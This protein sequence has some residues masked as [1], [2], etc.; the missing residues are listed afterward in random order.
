MVATRARTAG[1]VVAALL[2]AFSVGQAEERP[3]WQMEVTPMAWIAGIEGKITVD[4]QKTEFEKSASDLID[5][6]EFAG[7]V[8]G[9]VQ[10]QRWV[11]RAQ[12]DFLGMNTDE[13]DVEDRP[14]GGR[15]DT[16]LLLSELGA[17]YQFDGWREGQTFDL[18][19]GLRSLHSDHD[20]EVYAGENAGK[21]S[22][23][24]NL[25]D[26]L[27]SVRGSIPILP[28]KIKGLRVNAMATIGAGGDSDFVYELQPQIQYRFIENAAV[29]LGY[30]RVGWRLDRDELAFSLAGLNFGL[31]VTF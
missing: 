27:V 6:V 3:L 25:L 31:G 20:L 7:G 21:H 4:G 30:R 9:S 11:F 2:T 28:S 13:L 23:E 18:M 5:Y 24:S 10:Y 26:P 8:I 29:R 17:G 1:V 12:I 15:L 14:Q 19:I 16:D 22:A